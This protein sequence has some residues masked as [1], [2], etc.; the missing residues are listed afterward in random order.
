MFVS[1]QKSLEWK[2]LETQLFSIK[3][4]F[5][6]DEVSNIKNEDWRDLNNVYL[7]KKGNERGIFIRDY[8]M[9]DFDFEFFIKTISYHN[10]LNQIIWI[11]GNS[12]KVFIFDIEQNKFINDSETVMNLIDKYYIWINSSELNINNE[13]AWTIH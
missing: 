13:R 2:D 3:D 7:L 9:L 10:S 8:W 11:S 12:N 4:H 1:M 5:D 6:L